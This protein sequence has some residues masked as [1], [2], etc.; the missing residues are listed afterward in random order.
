MSKTRRNFSPEFKAQVFLQLL[1]EEYT[2][3]ELAAE[4]QIS[5]VVIGFTKVLL[6]RCIGVLF[7][8]TH[9]LLRKGKGSMYEDYGA[10]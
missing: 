9:S 3:N 4:H 2:V 1:R 10:L 5:P 6:T 7:K 8:D